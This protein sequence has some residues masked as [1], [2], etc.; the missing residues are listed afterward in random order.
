LVLPDLHRGH[1][2]LCSGLGLGFRSPAATAAW[3][4]LELDD[5][6]SSIDL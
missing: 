5:I 1:S 3:T 2:T 6:I 4:D